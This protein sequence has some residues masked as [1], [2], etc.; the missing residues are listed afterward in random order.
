[1]YVDEISLS[2]LALLSSDLFDV[3]RMEVLKGP[4]GTLYGRNST[5][6][7]LNIVSAKPTF[8]GVS[9]RLQ[10]GLSN[11]DGRE[12]EAVA[13]LPLTD[14]LALRIAER[15]PHCMAGKSSGVSRDRPGPLG[16]LHPCRS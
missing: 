5:A 2:S 15:R 3:E 10:A 13:N 12:L 16:N 7:A 1:M 8:D 6:G 14:A 9:G 4:Q 11:Y